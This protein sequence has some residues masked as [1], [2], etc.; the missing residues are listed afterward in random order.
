VRSINK[1]MILFA[2][3]GA[4]EVLAQDAYLRLRCDGD[5]AGAIVSINGSAKGE[6]PLDIAAPVGETRIEAV[7]QLPHGQYR[8]FQQTLTLAAGTFKRLD[9]VLGRV[10]FTAEGRKLEDERLAAEA[11]RAAAAAEQEKLRQQQQAQQQAYDKAARQ[12]Q[13]EANRGMFDS[14]TA[15]INSSDSSLL[16]SVMLTVGLPFTPISTTSDVLTGKEISANDPAAFSNP[17]SL[18]ARAK[19]NAEKSQRAVAVR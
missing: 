16:N 10:E 3:C 18:M 6:C 11:T 1:L 9:I 17:E 14:Y 12:A 13:I 7:K 19:R 4:G 2:F 5:N 15:M 8:Q